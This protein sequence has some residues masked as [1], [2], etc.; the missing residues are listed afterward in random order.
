MEQKESQKIVGTFSIASF[1][2]DLG[3]D[4][5][6]PIWPLFVTSI[7]GANVA[8]LGFIDGLG[9]AIVSLSQA[10]SG[11]LSD[12]LRKR[13][14]FIWTGYFLGAISRIGY[15][16]SVIW[17]QSIPFRILD[18]SGKIRGS[19][20]DAIVADVSTKENRGRNF[21]LLRAMDNLGAVFGILTCF[22]LFGY[23]GYKKL[24]FL[25]SIPS[26]ISAVLVLAFIK[27]RKTKRIYKGLALKDLTPNFKL[28][29]LLSALFALGSFSYS[30]LLVYAKEFGF[31]ETLTILLYLEF[32]A[33]ASVMSLPFGKL[34]DKLKRKTVLILSYFLFGLM[35]FGFIFV[36]SYL[37]IIVL[38]AVYG[39]HKAAI[40]PVQRTLV[41]E[42]S[43]L[44]YRASTLG[45]FQM[46]T[47][48]C[49]LPASLLAGLLWVN[50]GK[51]VPFYFSL[52]LTVLAIILM[53]FIEEP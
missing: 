8:V 49:A 4:M 10:G 36:K 51:S 16:L 12:R 13:K 39:L 41:S 53:L 28:F 14:V 5:I 37:G 11:Y 50:F 21:G 15:A 18:R 3:S 27:E 38:F 22:L 40:D 43:P 9:E 42:L 7:L 23:L 52:S 30:F 20:R 25:A 19:P 44:K 33:V 34:A 31:E 17:Q 48:L 47:G 2:N 6:Y 32:T 29:L 46:V 26:L 45:A 1:L 24:F 35:C